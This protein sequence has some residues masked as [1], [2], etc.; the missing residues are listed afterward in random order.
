MSYANIIGRNKEINILDRIYKSKKS[1]LVAIYGRRR[2]GKSYLVSECFG[3]KILFKAVGTYIKD[4]DKDYESYRQLQLA[5]FYDSLVIA[6]LSTKESKPT[7]WREAFLL[8]RKVLEGK[9][10]RRKIIFIDELPW[11]AGP[12][13]SEMIAELGYFWNSWADSE[14]NIILIV[15][16]SATSWMLDNVIHDYG[17]LH[18]R[19]TETIKLFPFTLAECEKYYKKN[20]F[21]LS[22]YEM[23]VSYM[24][25]GGIPYYLDKL[26]NDRTMTDNIDSIFFADELIHQE[27]KDVYTG[28]YSSKEKYVD[29]VKAIGSKFY[30]MTQSELSK[31][32]GIKTGGTLTKLLDNLR[33]SG[34]TR[35]YP[36]YGKERVETVYQL[37]D[38]FSL[39]YLRF[40]HG[41][42][43]KQGGWNA[44]HGTARFYTW[45]G[46]TFE[47][48]SIEHLQNIQDTLRIHS[49]ERNYSWCGKAEDGK[50]A[51]I[52]LVMESKS[53]QTD[54][55]C[56]MKFST[57]NFTITQDVEENIRH[58]IDAFANSKMHNKTRSIQTVLVTTMGLS[59]NMHASIINHLITLEQLFQR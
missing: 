44:I 35:E 14:R 26:R 45:A 42:Q 39:F 15:C 7:C 4:G 58:K 6:G 2:V 5:H 48:L 8:L 49:V 34:I 53:T 27:F 40:V 38:F 29:I 31:A 1:E 23:C 10:N 30:G 17:G 43:V 54:Y 51:Q 52:D 56:E 20:G 33:E 36:R 12:Q 50:G 13:S 11:L 46:D 9:R 16:G 59:S 19:L 47:L 41:K 57:G 37:K 22:R 25:I 24:A 28:L 55:L 18:G 21:H 3:K 32:T